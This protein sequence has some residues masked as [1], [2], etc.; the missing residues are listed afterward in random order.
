M[1]KLLLLLLILSAPA[2]AA[3]KPPSLFIADLTWPEVKQAIESGYTRILVPTAGTEQNGNHVVLGKHHYVV[4]YTSEQIA[5]KQGNTLIAPIIDYVP[6]QPHQMFPGT[7]SLSDDTFE[8]LLTD[9]AESLKRSGFKRIYFIG[10]SYGNQPP[11]AEVVEECAEDFAQDGVTLATLNEYYDATFNGQVAWL[12]NEGFTEAQI[13]GHVGIR[14]TSEM[15]VA[16]PQGVRR[17][18]IKDSVGE[19][20]SGGNGSATKASA[21]YGRKMLDLKIRAALRQM[22]RIERKK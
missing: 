19:D 2:H 4:Q 21:V 12:K 20:K 5:K 8:A 13:G 1:K 18:K 17:D 11:Q 22:A 10:D 3:Y 9:T 16:H 15:L 6:E 7:I 14:D